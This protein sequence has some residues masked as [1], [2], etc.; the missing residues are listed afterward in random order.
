MAP[1][2]KMSKYP[3]GS[4]ALK[5]LIVSAYGMDFEQAE[6]ILKERPENPALWPYEEYQKAKAMMAALHTKPQV[7]SDKPGWKRKK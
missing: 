5:S 4:E 1:R 2:S 6:T 7:V 3:P